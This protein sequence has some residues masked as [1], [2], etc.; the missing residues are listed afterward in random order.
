M[1][2]HHP[3]TLAMAAKSS[4]QT[5]TASIQQRPGWALFLAKPCLPILGQ[6][7]E[8]IDG[9]QFNSQF[10]GDLARAGTRAVQP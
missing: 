6:I 2:L 4:Q 3:E 10:S 1:H 5:F 8:A 7:Q 9:F